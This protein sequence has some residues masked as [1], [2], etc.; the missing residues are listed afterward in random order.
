M[1]DLSTAKSYQIEGYDKY[2][3]AEECVVE[4]ATDFASVAQ[5]L[6]R[7]PVT[8]HAYR[9]VEHSALDLDNLSDEMMTTFEEVYAD[10]YLGRWDD[11]DKLKEHDAYYRCKQAIWA[12]LAQFAE[13]LPV[14]RL[15]SKP[16]ASH[17]YTPD[18]V[19]AILRE[20]R[21]GWFREVANG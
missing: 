19:V 17:A 7:A 13:T 18:E 4:W 15:E 9:L 3:S 16:F 6:E 8:V 10:E 20:V 1:T 2:E 12:A 14:T 21:P 5:V 11:I